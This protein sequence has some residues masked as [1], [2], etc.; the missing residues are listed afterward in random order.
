MGDLYSRA[1]RSNPP[2]AVALWDDDEELTYAAFAERVASFAA[3]MRAA[4]LKRGDALAQLSGNRLDAIC[5][6]A[7]AFLRPCVAPHP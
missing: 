3:A 1:L 4:G 2:T 6:I 7:A 5:T